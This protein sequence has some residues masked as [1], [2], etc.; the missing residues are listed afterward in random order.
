M[1]KTYLNFIVPASSDIQVVNYL[2]SFE[3]RKLERKHLSHWY[4]SVTFLTAF[5]VVRSEDACCKIVIGRFFLF[6]IR[7]SF[8]WSLSLVTLHLLSF[9]PVTARSLVTRV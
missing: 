1:N 2:R 6:V 9:E 7:G 8:V 5:Y 3:R 4:F